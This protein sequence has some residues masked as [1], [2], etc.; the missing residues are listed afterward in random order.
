MPR[1][2]VSSTGLIEHCRSIKG[3]QRDCFAS[4]KEITYD[5]LWA[6]D[7]PSG[8]G[9]SASTNCRNLM[10]LACSKKKKRNSKYLAIPT[11]QASSANFVCMNF[12]IDSCVSKVFCLEGK[13]KN[14][15]SGWI[16]STFSCH[17]SSLQINPKEPRVVQPSCE[18]SGGRK[19]AS[20][21]VFQVVTTFQSLHWCFTGFTARRHRNHSKRTHRLSLFLSNHFTKKYESRAAR[22]RWIHHDVQKCVWIHLCNNSCLRFQRLRA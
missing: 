5:P 20:K 2:Q 16:E 9:N 19:F 22:G 10:M 7:T 13:Q 12:G 11:R 3:P 6:S 4:K 21:T 17:C 14:H 8:A 18:S 1:P 15:D